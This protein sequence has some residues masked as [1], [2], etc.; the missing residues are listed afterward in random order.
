MILRVM[1]D[2]RS[3]EPSDRSLVRRATGQALAPSPAPAAEGED[4]QGLRMSRPFCPK[5]G[6]HLQGA[7]HTTGIAWRCAS[8][9][10]QS[11]NFSQFRKMIPRDRV[12]EI[13]LTTNEQPVTAP[14][15]TPCP[16]CRRPMNAVLIPL[17]E[18]EVELDIC[19]ICQRLWLDSQEKLSGIIDISEKTRTGR[20]P[21]VIR[22]TKR[23]AD[24]PAQQ[25]YQEK[26]ARVQ[27]QLIREKHR[28]R[29]IVFQLMLFLA[30]Y[31]LFRFW[32][33]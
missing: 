8:C 20:K 6:I 28:H 14:G 10:G 11:L 27:V 29:P 13:W 9:Q 25:A 21:P 24:D 32:F 26:L 33:G 2:H 17:E 7:K 12:D 30:V 15:R 4:D 16:E 3:V 23:G 31:L 5:C 1:S 19:C 22:M 18:R